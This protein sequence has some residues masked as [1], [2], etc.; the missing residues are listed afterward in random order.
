MR[1]AASAPWL[2][3]PRP[4]GARLT[5]LCARLQPRGA[6]SSLRLPLERLSE[7]E[8]QLPAAFLY[9]LAV[10]SP[11]RFPA[12]RRSPAL[13]GGWR[14]ARRLPRPQGRRPSA[15]KGRWAGT[16]G[17]RSRS[18]PPALRPRPGEGVWQ[19][20]GGGVQGGAGGGGPGRSPGEG[21][22]LCAPGAARPEPKGSRFCCAPPPPLARRCH[23]CPECSH[24][25]RDAS[26]RAP[27]PPRVD[28][29]YPASAQ[30]P[31][32]R[33]A[34]ASPRLREQSPQRERVL[35]A[36]AECAGGG[37]LWTWGSVMAAWR[38]RGFWN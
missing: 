6:R 5:R 24:P 1:A 30:I 36:P 26:G 7:S 4:P 22:R 32:P 19:R 23:S 14:G 16:A 21:R 35:S 25:S 13:P 27:Q 34:G 9:R 17:R 2:S 11:R 3:L 15:E 8:R 33:R 29:R 31:G 28:A 18:P 12:M 37:G 10:P 38:E 20:A